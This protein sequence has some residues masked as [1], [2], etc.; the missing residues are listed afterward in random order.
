MGGGGTEEPPS[1]THPPALDFVCNYTP[2]FLLYLTNSKKKNMFAKK[3]QSI[4]NYLIP[5]QLGIYFDMSS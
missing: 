2:N 3:S 5:A 4:Q 1:P